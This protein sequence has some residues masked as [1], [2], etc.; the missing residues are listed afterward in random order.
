MSETLAELA[1][2]IRETLPQ[3]KCILHLRSMADAGAVTFAWNGREFIVKPTFQALEIK[4]GKLFVTGASMLLQMVLVKRTQHEK[5][6]GGIIECLRQTEELV[7]ASDNR[8][9]GLNLLATV[10]ATLKKLVVC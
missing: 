2:Y 9:Q 6:I 8:D 7:A 4:N 10:K 5:V 1:Q 3:P